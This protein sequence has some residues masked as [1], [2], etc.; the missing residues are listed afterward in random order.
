M[1]F[2]TSCSVFGLKTIV[3]FYILMIW[4]DSAAYLL[5][6]TRNMSASWGVAWQNKI[7]SSAKHRLDIVGAE[8]AIQIPFKFP[9]LPPSPPSG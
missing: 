4:P 9:L 5:R 6:I 1:E 7:V 3:D 2:A 8:G